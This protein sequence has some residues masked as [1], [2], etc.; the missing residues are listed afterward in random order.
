MKFHNI[1]SNWMPGAISEGPDN[2][3]AE[4]KNQNHITNWEGTKTEL[5]LACY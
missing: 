5:I 4:I 1:Y 2:N 3:K